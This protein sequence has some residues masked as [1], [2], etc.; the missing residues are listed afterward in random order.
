MI[1]FL[2]H[3]RPA[4]FNRAQ[5]LSWL[6]ACFSLGYNDERELTRMDAMHHSHAGLLMAWSW[7]TVAAALKVITMVSKR[8][9]HQCERTLT[10]QFHRQRKGN[11]F[12][13]LGGKG[14]TNCSSRQYLEF[15]HIA[16]RTL[17]NIRIFLRAE[18]GCRARKL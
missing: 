4:Y 8:P 10:K 12:V 5:V 17:S 3:Q 15:F 2:K 1:R 18:V 9:L 14:Y 6:N 16:I 7:T 13:A 11:K